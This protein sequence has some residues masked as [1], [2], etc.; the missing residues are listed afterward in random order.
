VIAVAK[1]GGVE[2]LANEG[3]HRETQNIIG[4]GD[5]ERFIGEQGALQSKSNFK[6]TVNFFTRFLGLQGKPPFYR[7]ETRWLTVSHEQN[8][9]GKQL[10]NVQYY[11]QKQ[12][13]TPE[14]LTASLLNKLKDIL[15]YNNINVSGSNV[16]ISVPTYYT[17]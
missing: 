6:N 8:S 14:Q 12:Q 11:G 2:V 1:K 10:F 7:D 5:R 15:H 16:V 3:S 17:E 9:N 4:F 13:Y